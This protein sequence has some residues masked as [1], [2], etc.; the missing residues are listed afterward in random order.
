MA[1]P[2]DLADRRVRPLAARRGFAGVGLT[3]KPRANHA[4]PSPAQGLD[5]PG[6]GSVLGA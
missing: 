5:F 2:P 1:L 4:K 3:A 6:R